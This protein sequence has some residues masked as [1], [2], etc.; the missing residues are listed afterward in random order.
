MFHL[1]EHAHHINQVMSTHEMGYLQTDL[2]KEG[3]IHS[4]KL[5]VLLGMGSSNISH[6]SKL[7]LT[8]FMISSIRREKI[9]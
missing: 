6:I 8:I 4:L 1:N 3:R 7:L 9:M 2:I 5:N